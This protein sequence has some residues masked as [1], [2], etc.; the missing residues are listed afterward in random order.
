MPAPSL[1]SHETTRP[2]GEARFRKNWRGKLVLQCQFREYVAD[3]ALGE[4]PLVWRD[5]PEWA[6]HHIRYH[7]HRLGLAPLL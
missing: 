1:P 4:Q 7:R 3:Q 6:L 2:T 5:A